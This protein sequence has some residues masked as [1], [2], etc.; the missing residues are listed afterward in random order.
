MDFWV[1]NEGMHGKSCIFAVINHNETDMKT[2][3][4]FYSRN[5]VS[6]LVP[7]ALISSLFFLWGFAHSILEVL[8]PHFQ[9]SFKISKTMAAFVQA[10]VYGGYF[11]MALPAGYIIKR[12]GYRSGVITGLMLYGIGAL[13][14]I[15]GSYINSFP[16]FVFSLFV[17]GCGLTCLETSANPYTTVLGAPESA[18]RR[19]NLSQSLNGLGWIVG[20]LVGGALLFTGGSIAV[21]YTIV[22]VVVLLVALVFSRVRLPEIADAA[23]E[24]NTSSS[25]GSLWNGV[26]VMGLVALFLYVAAQTG[27][28][29]FFINYMVENVGITHTQ[30]SQWL[31]FGG[32]GLFVVGRLSGSWLMGYIRAER[33]LFLYAVLATLATA[34]IVFGS[35]MTTM[36]AF[37]VVY[38]CESIMF[39]TIFSLALRSSRGHTKQASSLLI[40]TIVGGAVAPL[41]MGG[42]ADTTGS[43]ARAFVVPLVCYIFISIYSLCKK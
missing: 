19:I 9:E 6:Y 26:F 12:W 27:V 25:T 35:G 22:G 21:P 18:E 15:P 38:L 40:M 1:K 20:P 32:M 13:L 42:I 7:F 30:A 31:G 10:A 34:V 8:N 39:P 43:M 24:E 5:G 28:N 37:F 29:S 14:F 36:A 33:L 23:E 11:L 41:L 2:G 4:S 17:I 3:N 16:F